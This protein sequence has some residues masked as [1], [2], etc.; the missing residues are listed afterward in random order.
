[1]CGEKK[2]STNVNALA[3]Y[4]ERCETSLRWIP[5][6]F[7][8]WVFLLLLFNQ[9]STAFNTKFICKLCGSSIT[10]SSHAP[11]R[12]TYVSMRASVKGR[13][14]IEIHWPQSKSTN[15]RKDEK[16]EVYVHLWN[17]HNFKRDRFV[18]KR[19]TRQTSF[20]FRSDS[21]PFRFACECLCWN[22]CAHAR[23]H[24]H[25]PS[26]STRNRSSSNS[27]RFCFVT[28]FGSDRIRNSAVRATEKWNASFL[29]PYWCVRCVRTLDKRT[30]P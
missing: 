5:Y 19:H 1:M 18:I 12:I 10:I 2:E 28:D 29:V 21:R 30:P 11:S 4:A 25:S 16:H 9:R 14:R 24:A 13:K 17:A 27:Q 23:T 15:R 26:S 7:H 22:T 8:I 3:R 20:W 6:I